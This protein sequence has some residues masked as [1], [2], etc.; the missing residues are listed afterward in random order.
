MAKKTDYQKRGYK[1]VDI[2]LHSYVNGLGIFIYRHKKDGHAMIRVE[3]STSHTNKEGYREHIFSKE[4]CDAHES[5]ADVIFSEILHS[6]YNPYD[7][8]IPLIRKV[9]EFLESDYN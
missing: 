2:F 9:M 1:F 7:N 4:L 8:Q 6:D 5:I 3:P